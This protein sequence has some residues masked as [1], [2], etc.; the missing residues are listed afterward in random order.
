[1]IGYEKVWTDN[2]SY[3]LH[4]FQSPLSDKDAV[5][6]TIGLYTEISKSFF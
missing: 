1:M 3:S 5:D 4:H 6:N 2:I